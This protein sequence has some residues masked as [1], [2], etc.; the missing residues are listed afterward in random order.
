MHAIRYGRQFVE[1]FIVAM[2]AM[3]APAFAAQ[4]QADTAKAPAEGPAAA[5]QDEE[6]I[7]RGEY[8]ATAG[9]CIACHT[10]PGGKPFA[11]GL[12]MPT[13]VGNVMTTNITP[14]KSHGIGNYTLQDFIV[15]VREGKGPDGK[16]FYPAMPYTSYALVTDDDL[17]AMYAYFMRDV[18][19]VDTKPAQTD[20]PFPFNIRASM[21]V[22]NLFF[23]Q[24]KP[25]EPDPGKDTVWNRG[26]YLTR[27]LAHCSACHTPRN[28]L[29]AE[30]GSSELAGADIGPWYAPNITSDPVSGI[31]DWS[32]EELV[33]YMKTG[34]VQGKAQTARPMA[35][36]IDH[37]L[38]YLTDEDLMAIAVYLKSVPAIRQPG[39]EK[40]A[41]AWGA[42]HQE[43]ASLRGTPLP[44]DPD[45]MTGAQ[46]YDA[47]CASCHQAQGQG[48]R[49]LPSLFHS[50]AVGRTNTNNLVM[51]ILDGITRGHGEEAGIVMPG[52]RNALSDTQIVNLSQYVVGHFGHPD[53]TVT[54]DQVA[55]LRRGEVAGPD[56]VR[57]AR[58]AIV[59]VA[60]L[61]LLLIVG[62]V[63]WRR[64]RRL[65][66]RRELGR[67]MA[68]RRIVR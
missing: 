4:A 39:E 47:E 59:A 62:A 18:E 58:V 41:H 51:V 27:G 66:R 9:D 40:P 37:S 61:V 28:A 46:L 68:R 60:V 29:M 64:R 1:L 15:A 22:W 50:S 65:A 30:K 52:Y 23:L 3:V 56:L 12:L 54:A 16:H 21:A 6:L 67:E 55:R 33:V 24:S 49:G 7:K 43:W 13:P 31:G 34:R 5:S 45:L 36:A 11:G 63:L 35:E 25:Y 20:L 38:Q 42:P 44:D 2:M 17:K 26:A 32:N 14:S 19:P 57:I 10:V 48:S 53:A 8:L